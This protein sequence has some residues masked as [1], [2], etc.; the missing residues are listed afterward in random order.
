M[1]NFWLFYIIQ[2]RLNKE[3]GND[4]EF[5]QINKQLTSRA[6]NEVNDITCYQVHNLIFEQIRIP[7]SNR[8]LQQIYSIIYDQI[9]DEYS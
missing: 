1:N 5:F 2:M 8:V 4:F 9:K 3:I 7:L 6:F